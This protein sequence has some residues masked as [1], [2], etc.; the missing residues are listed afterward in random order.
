MNLKFKLQIAPIP[1]ISRLD[2]EIIHNPIANPRED[3]FLW[4]G[5]NATTPY[6][7]MKIRGFP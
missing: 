2:G 6:E 3:N 1:S 5:N 7:L 4:R